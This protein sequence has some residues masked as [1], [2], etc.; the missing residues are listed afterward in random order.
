MA[1]TVHDDVLDAALNYIKN[2]ADYM[3]A[4]NAQP[5]TYAEASST[6]MLAGVAQ[7]S[8]N[9]TVADGASGRKVT[10]AARS[11]I[12]ISNT[13]TATYVALVNVATSKLL[14][15]TTC[16]ALYLTAAQLM[17]FGAWYIQISDPT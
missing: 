3:Y 10:M 5:T 14:Y 7:T 17:G 9:Y 1:K 16:T 11:D 15:V 8:S 6:Y 4:C 12:T 2:N 13:G